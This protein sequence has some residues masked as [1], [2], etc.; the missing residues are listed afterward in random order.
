MIDKLNY[1]SQSLVILF[2]EKDNEKRI[3]F[4]LFTISKEEEFDS[5]IPFS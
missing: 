3:L 2:F 1:S 4:I 5:L